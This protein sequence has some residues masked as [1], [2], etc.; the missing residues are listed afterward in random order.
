MGSSFWCQSLE[1]WTQSP[2]TPFKPSLPAITAKWALE[3]VRPSHPPYKLSSLFLHDQFNPRDGHR[4]EGALSAEFTP[5]EDH[6]PCGRRPHP[7]QYLHLMIGG[8]ERDFCR[9]KLKFRYRGVEDRAAAPVELRH[10][11]GEHKTEQGR[12]QG[13]WQVMSNRRRRSQLPSSSRRRVDKV[14]GEADRTSSLRAVTQTFVTLGFVARRVGDG[15]HSP[16]Q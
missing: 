15:F 8:S 11:P 12:S 3:K 1:E 7:T 16:R 9:K 5:G 13:H 4:T 10:Q 2:V 14:T 6:L